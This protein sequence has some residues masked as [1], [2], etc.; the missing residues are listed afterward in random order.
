MSNETSRPRIE[1]NFDKLEFDT[2]HG[3][4]VRITGSE[5]EPSERFSTWLKRLDTREFFKVTSEELQALRKP[6]VVVADP[7]SRPMIPQVQQGNLF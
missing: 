1:P 7:L 2:I 6:K 4:R 5:R 3:Y